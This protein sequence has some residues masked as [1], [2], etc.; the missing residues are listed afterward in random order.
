LH[1]NELED[2]FKSLSIQEE[3]TT[4]LN[5]L[6]EENRQL[7]MLLELKPQAQPSTTAGSPHSER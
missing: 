1:Q 3:V 5:R 7:K 4:E 2:S 6:R